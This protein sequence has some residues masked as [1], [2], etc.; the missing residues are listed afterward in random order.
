M[1]PCPCL[2]RQVYRLAG[3]VIWYSQHN[4]PI[5]VVRCTKMPNLECDNTPCQQCLRNGDG[6]LACA[7]GD[8]IYQHV[9]KFGMPGFESKPMTPKIVNGIIKRSQPYLTD[10]CGKEHPALQN[11]IDFAEDLMKNL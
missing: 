5:K 11:A 6:V 4:Y 8:L 9:T 7:L 3:R 1:T 10:W 2:R